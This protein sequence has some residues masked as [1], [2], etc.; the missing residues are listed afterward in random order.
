MAET[1]TIQKIL[2]TSGSYWNVCALHNAVKLGIFTLLDGKKQTFKEIAERMP[3]DERGV[4]MLLNALC[5]MGLVEKEGNLYQNSKAAKEYLSQDSPQ[6]IG[7]MIE[8]H[9]Q[10]VEGW[11]RLDQAVKSGKPTRVRSNT[12][13][14]RESFLM[15]MF[16]LAM[17]IAPGLARQIDFSQRKHILD[18]GGG[19]GTYCIQFCLANPQLFGTIYDLPESEEFAQKTIERFGLSQRVRFVGGD[20]L[21]DEIPGSYDIAWLSH[22][23]HSEGDQGCD[24]ILKKA[25]GSLCAGGLLFVHE[26]LLDSSK[27]QPLFASLFS[28]NMLV[29]TQ[30]GRSYSQE[31]IEEKMA[32][33]G[34]IEIQRLPFSGPNQSSIIVGKKA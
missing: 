17:S 9:A 29:N 15:G 2:E 6:Y 30:E 34:F 1:W 23:L 18:L 8:H 19:P 24:A 11:N 7:Y 16:N 5:G 12:K 21:K 14:E 33:A 20:Y 13:K 32:K 31:E 26:F 25:A 10:L 3:G 22:I 4:E 27:T 28:L